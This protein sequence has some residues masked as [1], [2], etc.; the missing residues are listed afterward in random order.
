MVDKPKLVKT[1]R[2]RSYGPREQSWPDKA[3]T[4][5]F[6]PGRGLSSSP[7]LKKIA[8]AFQIK[9]NKN[10]TLDEIKA[11]SLDSKVNKN[12]AKLV[13]SNL[14]NHHI[15]GDYGVECLACDQQEAEIIPL[16]PGSSV[17]TS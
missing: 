4:E 7:P 12:D 15:M 9:V 14:V 13:N 8:Q 16:M 1:P 5:Y 3:L 11:L 17:T 2:R 10:V 6:L